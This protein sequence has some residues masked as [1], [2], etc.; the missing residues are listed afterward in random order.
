MGTVPS[1]RPR[2]IIGVV[3]R[4]FTTDPEKLYPDNA[5]PKEQRGLVQLAQEVTVR[6]PSRRPARPSPRDWG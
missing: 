2:A 4:T 6:D 5:L 3:G 1:S